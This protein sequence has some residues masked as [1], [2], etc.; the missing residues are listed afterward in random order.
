MKQ[1]KRINLKIEFC[2]FTKQPKKYYAPFHPDI[3]GMYHRGEKVIKINTYYNIIEQMMTLIHEMVHFL[4]EYY[5]NVYENT[6]PE[7]K[8]DK[9]IMLPGET[10]EENICL[11]I[12][13]YVGK[14]IKKYLVRG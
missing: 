9:V 10:D 14:V 5:N 6:I 13:K 2:D 4:F 3:Q 12:D 11:K 1:G 8:A 7:E